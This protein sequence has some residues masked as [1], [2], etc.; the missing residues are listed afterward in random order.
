MRKSQKERAKMLFNLYPKL[1]DAYALVC[2]LRAIFRNKK[3]C[4]EQAKEQLHDWYSKV[5]RSGIKEISAAKDCIKEREDDV[6]N[7]F[8]N[9]STN[10]ASESNNAKMK[11]FRSEL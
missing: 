6:L 1:A 11:G 3:L 7:Y 2:S 8:I 9:R 10:A 5:S 4:R